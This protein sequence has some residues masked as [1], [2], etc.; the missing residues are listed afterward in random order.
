VYKG[1]WNKNNAF[2]V[3]N[4]DLTWVKFSE[5]KFNRAFHTNL[6]AMLIVNAQTNIIIE[7]NKGFEDI[8]GNTTD[9]IIGKAIGD[10]NLFNNSCIEALKD[11][12]IDE[13]TLSDYET[14]IVSKDGSVKNVLFSVS[15][16]ELQSEKYFFAIIND[17]TEKK[18]IDIALRESEFKFRALFENAG[19][20]VSYTIANTGE[21]VK[22]NN[23]FCEIVGYEMDELVGKTFMQITHPDDL[24]E[25]ILF[26]EQLEQGDIV[27]FTVKKRYLKKNGGIVWVNHTVTSLKHDSNVGYNLAIIED[28]TERIVAENALKESE[29]RY[30]NLVEH[31]PVGIML[32][33]NGVVVYANP[34]AVKALNVVSQ[35]ELI[36]RSAI[37]F[38][39]PNDR[40]AVTD[41]IR[42]MM[43]TGEPSLPK[44]E[45]FICADGVEKTLIVA[46]SKAEYHGANV[47]QVFGID[48]TTIKLLEAE[49]IAA[50]EKAEESDR[51]KSTFLA[52]M[53]HEIR[54]PMNGILGFSK[55]L[56]N[57][58]I[59]LD[60]RKQ[61]IDIIQSTTKQLLAIISDIVDI[62]KLECGSLYIM[63]CNFDVNI[64][65]KELY[66][67]FSLEKST[68]NKD[69][70]EFVFLN[71]K[72]EST[73][74]YA[75]ESRIRQVLSNFI[76]N[77]I[78]FTSKG[79]VEFGYTCIAPKRI[80]F[81]VKDTGIGIPLRMQTL[82]FDSFRQVEE[83]TA[84]T[85]GGSGL[86][87]A[88]SKGIV[89]LM[90][91]K[92]WV[93]SVPDQGSS[94][95][96]EVPFSQPSDDDTELQSNIITN[97]YSWKAHTLLIVEDV[98]YNVELIKEML[99]PTGISILGAFNGNEAVEMC[100]QH[101]EIELV[102]M[103]IQIPELNGYEATK[104][105]KSFRPNLPVIAQT[106]YALY[107][108]RKKAFDAGCVGYIAKPFNELQL[109]EVIGRFLK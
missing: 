64:M 67:Q 26:K 100:R 58:N 71:K 62:S 8:T 99:Q 78:K 14:D 57:E 46:A 13:K 81:Y 12:F 63:P 20:G 35:E 6:A 37:D 7:A 108:D 18:K 43:I 29:E 104:Q 74:V 73:M 9:E 54:T 93:E 45:R 25:N 22:L 15:L 98:N 32:H 28:I 30:R 44:E 31:A 89:E 70:L 16:F 52:N 87:L 5:E 69:H 80:M 10:I 24:E 91:G 83:S 3:I 109:I 49:L 41:R 66:T 82:I 75:D 106:A 105:I 39:H 51:L 23:K 42:K 38:I 40:E 97:Q 65:C 27:N 96:F 4:K 17:I 86:G 47:S 102:L 77:A 50:K 95:Y 61:Y 107:D 60:K 68:K 19:F 1:E 11:V 72:E 21:F 88:I 84:R 55:L 56:L 90:G 34:T 85:Y 36:G 79:R 53:S 76:N 103:D 2:F 48:I 94:F 101:P 33:A 92:I 59:T